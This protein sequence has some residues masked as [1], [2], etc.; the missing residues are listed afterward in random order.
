MQLFFII[1]Q[2]IIITQPTPVINESEIINH[3]LDHNYATVHIR[4]PDYTFNELSNFL[5]TID[6]D[7]HN[8]IVIHNHFELI[9]EFPLKGIHFTKHNK[10]LITNS[11]PNHISKSISTHSL[12]EINDLPNLFDYYFLSPIFKSTSK[13]GYGG[14]TFH[15]KDIKSYIEKHPT[16]KLIA[17]SGVNHNTIK[18]V[19]NLGFYGAAILGDFW[20]FCANDKNLEKLPSFFQLLNHA[21]Q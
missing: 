12:V 6:V 18:D 17:L 15:L 9:H 14:N 20:N 16:K 19:E 4:K 5:K 21:I 11:Y 10:H 13:P 1:M 7:N 8:K 2:Y 3:I